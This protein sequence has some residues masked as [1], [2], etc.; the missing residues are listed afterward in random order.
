MVG[1]LEVAFLVVE[2][3]ELFGP[4]DFEIS[5]SDGFAI[6]S[7]TERKS[8]P[9]EEE[10]SGNLYFL[11]L[12]QIEDLKP[13]NLTPHITFKFAPHGLSLF[14]LDSTYIIKVINHT[15]QGHSIEE[16]ELFNQLKSVT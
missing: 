13:I 2:E 14:K 3:I 8:Y 7:S 5:Y 16:F 15:N 4:E 11:D 1:R 10:E 12:N 9:A 6:I